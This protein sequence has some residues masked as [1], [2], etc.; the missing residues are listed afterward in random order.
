M[1]TIIFIKKNIYIQYALLF[2]ALRISH[3]QSQ[4]MAGTFMEAI[5]VCAG[6]PALDLIIR[7]NMYP[8][9]EIL[10][11]IDSQGSLLRK[12]NY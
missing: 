1:A 5:L 12:S 3:C 7:R 6:S 8:L 4:S 9:Q 10:Q 11:Q 2:H